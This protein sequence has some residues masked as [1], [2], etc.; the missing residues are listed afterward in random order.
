MS[1]TVVIYMS[2]NIRT[3]NYEVNAG[4]RNVTWWEK[5]LLKIIK[6]FQLWGTAWLKVDQM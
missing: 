4:I 3:I 5:M 6:Y 2:L 1:Q